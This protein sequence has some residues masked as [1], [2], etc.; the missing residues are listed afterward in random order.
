MRVDRSQFPKSQRRIRRYLFSIPIK[1]EV[2]FYDFYKRP[3]KLKELRAWGLDVV[4]VVEDMNGN[5]TGFP[6]NR[7]KD[8]VMEDGTTLEDWVKRYYSEIFEK[9]LF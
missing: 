1:E 2:F 5:L 9:C 4:A 8:Y 3:Y 6:L 7:M